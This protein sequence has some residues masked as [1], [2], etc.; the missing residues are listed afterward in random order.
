[1]N[2]IEITSTV[3]SVAQARELLACG[4]DNIYFGD[5]AFGLRLPGYFSR[6]E[7]KELVELAHSYNKKATIAVNGIMHPEKMTLIPEYLTFLVDI[8]VDQ[9]TV[10]DTGVIYVL[11]KE[12]LALPFIYDAHTLVTSAR[13]INF[14]G[15]RGAIGGVIAREVPYL[16][17]VDMT[18]QLDIFGE[19]LVYGAT[20]IHQSKRPLVENFFSYIKSEDDTS[21]E[22]GLFLS[23]PKKEETHYSVYEDSHGTHIFADS[24]VNLMTELDKLFELG[25]THWKL[26]GIYTPGSKL[27]DIA[28]LFVQAARILEADEWTLEVANQLLEKVIVL[29]PQERSLDTGFFLMDPDEVK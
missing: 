1:M 18:K 15:K 9:I 17:L 20:C 13:Q 6:A 12:K 24:D 21:K 19:I 25:L 5:E 26:D 3:E 28:K 27:V 8:G 14:W 11:Q 10:G 7:Q 29:H 23:E 22:R 16:E 4:V 2:K